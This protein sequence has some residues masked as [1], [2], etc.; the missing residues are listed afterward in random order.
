MGTRRVPGHICARAQIR[1]GIVYWHI[2]ALECFLG[3]YWYWIGAWAH[4]GTEMV[5]ENIRQ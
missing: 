1:K 5:P 3:A 2:L 4:M